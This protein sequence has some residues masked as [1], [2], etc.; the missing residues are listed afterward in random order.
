[1]QESQNGRDFIRPMETRDR[2]AVEQLV[3]QGYLE[4]LAI[5]NKKFY[6]SPMLILSIIIL[7]FAINHVMG[8]HTVPITSTLGYAQYCIGPCIVLLPTLAAIDWLQ[9]PSFITKLKAAVAGWNKGFVEEYYAPDVNAMSGAWVFEHKD[10]IAGVVLLDA[11]NAGQEIS[12]L[13]PSAPASASASSGEAS[14]MQEGWMEGLRQRAKAQPLSDYE[15]PKTAEIRHLNVLAPYRKH[16]VAT[17]LLGAALDMAFGLAPGDNEAHDTGKQATVARVIAMASPFT[18]GGDA[19]WEK[20]GFVAVP[21][22]MLRQELWREDE[23]VGLN[24]WQG[25]WVMVDREAWLKA[26]EGLYS[27]FAPKAGME[28]GEGRDVAPDGSL[29][30]KKKDQ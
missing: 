14:W 18:P 23:A 2:A 29:I 4:D 9:K 26:R 1:M 10:T 15:A 22:P 24:F 28:F 16:G 21:P 5:A 12:K 20:M 13:V 27:R 7:G 8:I 17:E 11:R 25:H 3:G 6:R 30:E 19:L